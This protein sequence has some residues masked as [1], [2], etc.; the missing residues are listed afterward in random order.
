MSSMSSICL[1]EWERNFDLAQIRKEEELI[2]KFNTQRMKEKEEGE[3]IIEFKKED[4]IEKVI[5]DKIK[6]KESEKY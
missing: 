4:R 6:K 2:K 1:K 5:E 3:K